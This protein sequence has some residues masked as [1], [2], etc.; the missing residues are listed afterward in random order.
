[1][2]WIALTIDLR[3]P[4]VQTPATKSF[5]FPE[6]TGRRLCFAYES[7]LVADLLMF[8]SPGGLPQ[9]TVFGNSVKVEQPSVRVACIGGLA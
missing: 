4:I 8:R 9:K 3:H 2:G 5:Y 7:L 6:R 1:M